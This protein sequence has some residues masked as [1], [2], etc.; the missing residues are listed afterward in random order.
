MRLIES[1]SLRIPDIQT[2]P[3]QKALRGRAKESKTVTSKRTQKTIPNIKM[4]TAR[5]K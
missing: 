1:K 3:N 2:I 4:V 5:A